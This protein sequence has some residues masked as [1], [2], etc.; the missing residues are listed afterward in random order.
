MV[1]SRKRVVAIVVGIA[2]VGKS[3]VISRAAELLSQKNIK[4]T[5]IVFGT[6]MFE[7]SKKM[8]LKN[9]DEMRKLSIEDQHLLQDIAA[10]RIAQMNEEIL[11]IDT[12]MFIKTTEGYYP[13]IP[14]RLL[15]ILKPSYLIMIAADPAEIVRRRTTD[16][17]RDRDIVSLENIR[18]ELEISKAMVAT[19]SVLT[20]SPFI[21]IANDNGM[22][23]NAASTIVNVLAKGS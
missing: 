10:K 4:A 11:I 12:H 23:D 3:T 13:G 22:I 5:I 20:G 14:S 1:E 17:T 15:E 6:L 16:N 19:S 8:G 9:R 7:E 18:N 2:G 21:L